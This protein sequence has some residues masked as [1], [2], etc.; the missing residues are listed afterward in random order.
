MTGTP[1]AIEQ[2]LVWLPATAANQAHSI[3]SHGEPFTGAEPTLRDLLERI[4]PIA[5]RALASDSREHWP[6]ITVNLD[7]KDS[8]AE[9]FAAIRTLLAE[10]EAWLTTALRTNDIGSVQPLSL[11]P[12]L[13]L[14]GAD[15]AQQA[16]F[17][18]EVPIGSRR[19]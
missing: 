8:H 1:L 16:V 18:D 12:V 10:Y 5:T 15:P 7:F 2:D 6:L 17:H 13:V 19:A 9:H 4:R 14:T 3:V 11:G